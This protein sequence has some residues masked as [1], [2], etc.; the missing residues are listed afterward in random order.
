MQR[1]E[2]IEILQQLKLTAMIESFDEIVTDGI[3]RKRS[4]MDILGRLLTAEQTCDI[5]VGYSIAS[6][7][8]GFH[9]IKP[10][11]NLSLDKARYINQPLSY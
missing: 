5:S 10:W 6:I 8:Q 1:H 3:R 7:K 2:C 9:N 4:T 11:Q